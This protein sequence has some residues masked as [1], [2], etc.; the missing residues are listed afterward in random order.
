MDVPIDFRLW[1]EGGIGAGEEVRG[2]ARGDDVVDEVVEGERDDD[3]V[4]VQGEGAEGEG[5]GEG[6][7]GLGY[8]G[9]RCRKGVPHGG[10]SVGREEQKSSRM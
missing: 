9:W 1:G 3:F 8:A 4:S 5:G 6:L 2:E 10:S 7:G